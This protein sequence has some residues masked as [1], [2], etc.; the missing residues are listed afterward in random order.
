MQETTKTGTLTP[1]TQIL[2]KYVSQLGYKD[3]PPKI[4]TLI[5]Y[6]TLDIMGVGLFGSTLPWVRT[7]VNLWN[8]WGGKKEATVW[9]RNFKLP[10]ANAVL[11]NAHAANSFEFD[12]TYVK[13]GWGIH[14][15]NNVVPTAIALS[16]TK[17]QITGKSFLTALTAGHEVA[18]RIGMGLGRSESDRG[19]YVTPIC[20]TF[21]AAATASKLLG[22]D[23]KQTVNA[24]G[25]AGIYVGGILTI[26]PNSMAKRMVAARAAQGGVMAALLARRGFTGPTNV[27]EATQ[28]GFLKAH[29]DDF[30]MEKVIG[31]LG[32]TYRCSDL[33]FKRFPTCT[34]IHAPLEASLELVNKHDIPVANIER[35]LVR[36]AR[37]ALHNTVGFEVDTVGAAQMNLPYAVASAF[38]DKEISVNQ[39]TEKRI[40]DRTIKALSKR[41]QATGDSELTK[42]WISKAG[43]AGPG[44][45]EVTMRNGSKFS[46][47]LIPEA[48]PMKL[49]EVEQK[50]S[51]LALKVLTKRKV[52]HI[53]RIVKNLESTHDV[54]R[55]G[56]LL[57]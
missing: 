8:E 15:G 32:D 53:I 2:A 44:Q 27:I 12:D 49:D 35:I 30:D 56:H 4:I 6:D 29:S 37:G 33:H 14:P 23:E 28:G 50:F 22:L 13:G 17:R 38:V 46:S 36:T 39:F 24:L 55:L 18:I 47:A 51:K 25:C 3:I 16:E 11:S 5:K 48:T 7:A 57:G 41:V 52:E 42:M 21:G 34:S 26:P 9:G 31:E 43:Y 20:S 10:T 19:F 45:V 1:A 54:S 40:R